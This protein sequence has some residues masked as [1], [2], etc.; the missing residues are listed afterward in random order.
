MNRDH[1]SDRLRRLLA[2][3]L[4]AFIGLGPLAT[5]AY[6]AAF[7]ITQLADEPLNVRN[8]SKPNIVLTVDDSTSM[9]FDFLPD[10]V[11]NAYCRDGTGRMAAVC[12]EAGQA[13]D[14]SGA[15][16]GKFL[17][18]GYIAQQF[19]FPYSTYATGYDNS[20]PGAG[21]DLSVFPPRCSGGV[22]PTAGNSAP[23]GIERYPATSPKGGKLYEYTSLWPAPVHSSAFNRLYYN[24]TL[25]YLAPVAADGTSFQSMNVTN[26]ATW[27]KVPADP[28]ATTQVT[29]DL[30]SQVTVGQWCNSDWTQGVNPVTGLP[31]VAD[32]AFC[33]TNGLVAPASQGAAAADGDYT[34][35]WVPT[36]MNNN[37]PP[38]IALSLAY[39]KVDAAGVP[40]AAFLAAK[41]PKFF[42]Q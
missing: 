40:T 37:N 41:D 30:T 15:G 11:I 2:A 36:G 19:K 20:G 31:F 27:T 21:C 8:A 17:S 12:G 39:S 32:P 7:G 10:Y 3:W 24:P 13:N 26:T 38:N 42:Y 14:F 9:L 6:A 25:T 5:P 28:W 1:R 33:R 34:Y 4:A 29:V 16:Y 22:D 35:P 23:M 18:P